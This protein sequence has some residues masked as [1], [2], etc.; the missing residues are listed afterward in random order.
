MSFTL[1]NLLK[2]TKFGS[3]A[4]ELSNFPYYQALPKDPISLLRWRIYVRGRC[5][6]DLEFRQAI[7][8]MCAKDCLFF[9]ATFVCIHETRLKP[10]LIP[11][12]LW[13]D[14]ADVTSWICGAVGQQ[15]I[16]ISKS[17]GIG[18]SWLI[19]AILFWIWYF[20]PTC[21][22]AVVS[23]DDQSLDLVGRPATLM[24]KLDYIFEHLPEW[25]KHTPSGEKILK[26]TH[27]QHRFTNTANG[28]SIIGFVP[29]DDKLR[30]GRFFCV[31]YDEFAFLDSD[32]QRLMAAGQYVTYCRIFLSTFNGTGGMFHR[33]AHDEKSPLLR[34]KTFWWE[35]EDRRRG[36]YRFKS[37]RVEI[38]DDRFDFPDDYNFIDDGLLRSPYFDFELS[39][40]GASR[41]A[42]LE[43]LNGVAAAATRKLFVPELMKTIRIHNKA[44]LYRGKFDVDDA[45]FIEDMQCDEWRLWRAPEYK[46]G[47]I[48]I[49]ID[50]SSGIQSGAYGAMA[51][52]DVDTGEQVFTYAGH[53][54]PIDLAR[55]AV[56]AG[57]FFAGRNVYAVISY[58]S[59]G[60]VGGTLANELHRLN[61]PRIYMNEKKKYGYQNSDKGETIL[62]E[63]GRAI[64]DGE[65]VMYDE[66]I[67]DELEGFEYN[68]DQE[69]D[70]AGMD[71]HADRAISLAI[72]WNAAKTRRKALLRKREQDRII[73][74][75]GPDGEP[76][77]VHAKQNS[78]LWSSQFRGRI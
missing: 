18:M 25:M 11:M 24:G 64:R 60:P 74:M 66:I 55:L 46:H 30:S 78:Q 7:L 53:E 34:I 44:P 42:T 48:V 5:L 9:I 73:Q 43:E 20:M 23:K 3:P 62:H 10:R 69:L 61:Y 71:G 28:S 31:L 39:R 68:R 40:A 15:D 12:R 35:N 51:G 26:R 59:T 50:P 77:L 63:L 52:I 49:G 45:R 17:R 2:E 57:K 1:K 8:Q 13:Q 33:L 6:E 37:G 36:M 27:T 65:L 70:W 29:T 4:P 54:A 19:I 16:V 47:E 75:S 21:D 38:L 76:D 22:V 67:A 56:A 58:E 72:A 32:E 14:Q 41:Q